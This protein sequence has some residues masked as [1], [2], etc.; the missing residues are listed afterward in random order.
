MTLNNIK[1]LFR[2]IVSSHYMLKGF[3]FGPEYEINGQ[4]KPGIQ[5]YLLWVSPIDS[6]TTAQ[7][8]QRKFSLM[9]VGLVKKDESNR[10]EVWSDTEQCLDDVIKILRLESDDYTL[11]GD[12]VATPGTLETGDGVSGWH[13]EIVIETDLNSNYCDIPSDMIPAH[14]NIDY[15][16]VYDQNGNEIA[17][18][19]PGQS[20][21]VIVASGI[22]EG[23]SSQTYTIQIVDI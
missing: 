9:V 17:K 18:L 4:M 10:D 1:D 8:K 23:G 5:Y 3:G 16:T 20:Y 14:D 12:P 6:V 2:N 11:I 19:R 7:T 21:N 15:A 13:T 22:D